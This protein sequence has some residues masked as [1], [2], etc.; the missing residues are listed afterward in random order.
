MTQFQLKHADGELVDYESPQM[1]LMDLMDVHP[2]GVA[3]NFKDEVVNPQTKDWPVHDG[4]L[5]TFF[6]NSDDATNPDTWYAQL[7]A[8]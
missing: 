1:A 3:K 5:F 4:L 7:V 8:V 2:S 6:E